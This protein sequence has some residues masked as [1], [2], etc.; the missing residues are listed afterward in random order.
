MT[1]KTDGSEPGDIRYGALLTPQ[2][3]ILTDLF[4]CATEH[5]LLIDLPADT[6]AD[7]QKRLTLLKLRA[8]VKF[9]AVSDLAVFV[10]EHD[11]PE[12]GVQFSA[13]D[14]RTEKTLTR[15]ISAMPD[16]SADQ[17]VSVSWSVIRISLNLPECGPDYA[18]AS[19]FPADVNM[20]I[21]GG[22]DFR[23][24]CF[25][26]QEV[27]SRMKR[28]TEIRKR[29]IG[30]SADINAVPGDSCLAGSVSAGDI[31]LWQNGKGLMIARLDKIAKAMSAGELI[32][33][34]DAKAQIHLPQSVELPGHD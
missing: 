34:N 32:T 23:K 31:L 17:A 8:D 25:V 22:I 28:K 7:T 19:V 9:E 14:P 33:I 26:G 3:K 15:F 11:L 5:D 16:H 10:T 12:N 27:V 20:D 29:T 18:P 21:L 2:G 1:C 6:L 24:G 4:V 30:V 13:Q